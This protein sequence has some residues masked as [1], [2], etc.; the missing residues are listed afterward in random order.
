MFL[1]GTA[2][3]LVKNI[4]I[5]VDA[6]KVVGCTRTPQKGAPFLACMV[7]RKQTSSK[8]ALEERKKVI[9]KGFFV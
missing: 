1:G 4:D 2:V 8:L 6:H 7:C 9:V 3:I 5:F